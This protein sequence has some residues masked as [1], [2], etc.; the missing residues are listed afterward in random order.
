MTSETSFSRDASTA[1]SYSALLCF[2]FWNYGYGPALSL[3]R[4]ELHFSYTMLGV[5]TAVWSIG[6]VMTGITFPLAARRLS[7][8]ALLW[9]SGALATFGTL[10]F[11]A[12]STTSLTLLG[13]WVL[14][15]GGTTL[16]ATIQGIL[17]D[18]HGARRDR[19]LTEA[20]IG[21]AACAVVAPLAL[22]A[23]AVGPLGW[24]VAYL[25]PAVGLGWLFLRYRRQPMPTPS[26]RRTVRRDGRLPLAC[27][28][29]A[30]LAAGGM[31]VEF[32]LVYFGAEQLRAIGL[33]A[34]TA[35]F[36]MSSHFLG[37]LVGRLLGATA[38]RRPGR[39][40]P[41]L[42]LSLVTTTSGFLLFWL[43]TAPLAVVLGLF[44]AGL[45]IA[46]LYP[47]SVA[48]SLG[49]ADGHEDRANSLSQLL[50][51]L[52]VI[53]A[54]YL[55]GTVADRFGLTTAFA[56]EPVL[57]AACLALLLAGLRAGSHA[58]SR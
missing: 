53:T 45:G 14:G 51:G 7:R 23:L 49:A 12:G 54:P 30:G 36:A 6:T 3:L 32:C 47:L 5:H 1:L 26:D 29:F 8:A 39:T 13:G 42:H 40:V 19:A 18:R 9:G 10:A 37:L 21:A 56:I 28:V 31:G 34:T 25:L 20:N 27:W 35:T 11:V 43:G 50:G 48:L 52:V 44:V 57:I 15:L 17:S 58:A 2:A 4:D 55:L 24:R 46:N 33:T 22:G 16:L 38:T 41:L